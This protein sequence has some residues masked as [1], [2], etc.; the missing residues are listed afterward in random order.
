MHVSCAN[1][2]LFLSNIRLS[3]KGGRS[4]LFFLTRAQVLPQRLNIKMSAS[5]EQLIEYLNDIQ[6]SSLSER[7]KLDLYQPAQA[8]GNLP[9]IIYIHGGGWVDRDKSCK[10]DHLILNIFNSFFSSPYFF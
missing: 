5:N 1:K 8:T 3:S 4:H 7:L 2:G 9:L 6:Y 10:L